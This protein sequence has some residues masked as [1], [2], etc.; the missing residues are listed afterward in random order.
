MV[1][2]YYKKV[3]PWRFQRCFGPFTMLLVEES[4]KM[5]LFRHLSNHIFRSP[6]FEKYISYGDHLFVQNIQNLIYISKTLKKIWQISLCV[7][8]NCIWISSVKW[9]LLRGECLSSVVNV[10]IGSPKNFYITKRNFFQLNIVFS[11][12]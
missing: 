2:I 7:I 9:S 4:F 10:L 5:G 6:Y 3:Q 8:D 11:N 12:Y 1:I